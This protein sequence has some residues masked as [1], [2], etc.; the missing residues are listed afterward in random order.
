MLRSVCH[1]ISLPSAGR[2]ATRPRAANRAFAD[3]SPVSHRSGSVVDQ[4]HDAV[5]PQLSDF[6]GIVSERAVSFRSIGLFGKSG[7]ET[8]VV[9]AEAAAGIQTVRRA[10]VRDLEREGKAARRRGVPLML[11]A[12]RSSSCTVFQ[13]PLT[14]T[15]QLGSLTLKRS[16]IHLHWRVLFMHARAVEP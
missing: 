3:R 5:S 4:A 15:D 11:D 6:A 8:G 12:W 9:D 14:A 1:T 10:G 13:H 7:Q 16:R 2:N